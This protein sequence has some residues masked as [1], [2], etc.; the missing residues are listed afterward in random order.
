MKKHYSTNSTAHAFS[1]QKEHMTFDT[2][3][4]IWYLYLACC[5]V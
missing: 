3:K 2:H 4:L 5:W 1:T